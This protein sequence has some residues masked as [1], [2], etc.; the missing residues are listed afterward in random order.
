MLAL[1]GEPQFASSNKSSTSIHPGEDHINRSAISWLNEMKQ[2]DDESVL[3]DKSVTF[4]A[5]FADLYS[6]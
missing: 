2:I 4:S 5:F 3:N 6:K 1:G